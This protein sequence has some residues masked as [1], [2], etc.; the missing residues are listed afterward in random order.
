VYGDIKNPP[1]DEE[2]ACHPDVVYEKSKLA[3]ETAIL[4]YVSESGYEVTIVRPAW[5]YGPRCPRTLRLFRAI[6]KRRFFFV[7]NGHTLRHPIYISDMTR[8]FDVVATHHGIPGE[9]FIMAGPC[10]VTIEELA[11]TIAQCLG[12]PTPTLRFP[13][14]LVWSGAFLLELVGK[15]LGKDLPVSRR[16]LKFFTGNTAFRTKKAERV[17]GFQP[18]VELWDGIQRTYQWLLETEQI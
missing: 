15:V 6:K 4:D 11:R 18:Q 8:G 13:K 1:A 16:S 5:V 17:L 3:G 12:V 2:S 7:G 9:V 14:P 10:A